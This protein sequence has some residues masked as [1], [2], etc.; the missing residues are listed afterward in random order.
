MRSR[1]KNGGGAGGSPQAAH[2]GGAGHQRNEG[3][4][5]GEEPPWMAAAPAGFWREHRGGGGSLTAQ[6]HPQEHERL[7]TPQSPTS[8][9]SVSQSAIEA[10][11]DQLLHQLLHGHEKHHHLA[12]RDGSASRPRYDGA[13]D[14]ARDGGARG[15]DAR[16]GLPREVA[17]P[18]A[19]VYTKLAGTARRRRTK[20]LCASRHARVHLLTAS[21]GRRASRRAA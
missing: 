17:P 12:G 19:A 11:N 1:I 4:P 15:N 8:Y 6:S 13:H 18:A 10:R 14:G 7:P 3:G 9:D 2:A 16:P 20:R 21:I 5:A